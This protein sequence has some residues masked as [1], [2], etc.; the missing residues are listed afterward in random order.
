VSAAELDELAASLA[1]GEIVAVPTDTVYGLAVD[2]RLPGAVERLF[3]LK[4]RPELSALPVLIAKPAAL[5]DLAE[6]PPP[7]VRLAAR[8]W[9]GA[10]TL[11]L[12]RLSGVGFELGGDPN[13]IGLRC[14]DNDLLRE[15]LEITG[16]LAVT[17]AN[18]HGDP[19]CHTPG[20]VRRHLGTGV[21]HVLDGGRCDGLPSTVV[22]LVSG[23]L[24]CLRE[25]E[26]S[27]AELADFAA[28]LSSAPPMPGA[29]AAS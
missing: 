7:A 5:G 13:T 4:G 28:G 29:G 10:L 15:L 14:P 6:A 26:V 17:S 8:Y 21:S 3:A 9:P 18:H 11:V 22:S 24:Q 25:G 2:P 20:A 1:A 12:S 23:V 16:P 19:P 27:F